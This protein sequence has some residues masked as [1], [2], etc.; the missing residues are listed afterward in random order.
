MKKYENNQEIL[1]ELVE[2]MIEKNMKYNVKVT[3]TN[4]VEKGNTV[5][6]I[7]RRGYRDEVVVAYFNDISFTQQHLQD[8]FDCEEAFKNNYS[9]IEET[10]KENAEKRDAE[11]KKEFEINTSRVENIKAREE[12]LRKI[13]ENT[14]KKV[15][16]TL[17]YEA[18]EVLSNIEFEEYFDL[19]KH[20]YRM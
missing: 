6:L 20:L 19:P 10:A 8:L 2:K 1:D 15:D 4:N 5:S 13:K 14:S 7:W 11:F 17:L 9:S 18:A 3:Y 16:N 12:V